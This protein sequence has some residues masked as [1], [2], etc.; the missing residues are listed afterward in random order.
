MSFSRA[1]V[2]R[3]NDKPSCA[4]PG[5][6]RPQSSGKGRAGGEKRD[7]QVRPAEPDRCTPSALPVLRTPVLRRKACAREE[8]QVRTAGPKDSGDEGQVSLLTLRVLALQRDLDALR[9]SRQSLEQDHEARLAELR[10]RHGDTE[11]R[12][13][14]QLA[15]AET[16]L[17]RSREE[18]EDLKLG[19]SLLTEQCEQHVIENDQLKSRIH[20]LEK[21]RESSLVGSG[22]LEKLKQ[23]NCALAVEL[24]GLHKCAGEIHELQRGRKLLELQKSELEK[25][26]CGKQ[27]MILSLQ[28]ELSSAA[29][30]LEEARL[31]NE[32]LEVQ[33]RQH[34]ALLDEFQARLCREHE[35][36]LAFSKVTEEKLLTLQLEL[37]TLVASQK[38][39]V[40]CLKREYDEAISNFLEETNSIIKSKEGTVENLNQTVQSNR[41]MLDDLQCLLHNL[42]RAYECE[43]NYMKESHK[44]ELLKVFFESSSILQS[45]ESTIKFLKEIL[46]ILEERLEGQDCRLS[47]L[48]SIQET[49]I[50]GNCDFKENEHKVSL[51]QNKMAIETGLADT[52]VS[53]ADVMR[54]H[55]EVVECLCKVDMED[56]NKMLQENAGVIEWKECVIRAVRT[57]GSQT[58]RMRAALGAK[59]AE[60]GALRSS[61]RHAEDGLSRRERECE[62][63]RIASVESKLTVM[64]LQDELGR[65]EVC[66]RNTHASLEAVSARLLAAERDRGALAGE[67]QRLLLEVRRLAEQLEREQ[68]GMDELEQSVKADVECVKSDLL[69]RLEEL[70]S[71]AA[72]REHALRVEVLEKQQ[73]VETL[74]VRLEDLRRKLELVDEDSPGRE[75]ETAAEELRRQ[76]CTDCAAR[77][78]QEPCL[79]C[80]EW[81][82][83]ARPGRDRPADCFDQL[84]PR[85]IEQDK[86]PAVRR[87]KENQPGA[88]RGKENQPGAPRHSLRPANRLL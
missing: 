78:E 83:R 11:A 77:P 16:R 23:V 5:V 54:K 20:I 59:E 56:V 80:R 40:N 28:S 34:T 73:M 86:E 13:Q 36:H 68:R 85:P 4:P 53:L 6:Y 58:E 26:V 2:Q 70:R 29:L 71:V 8:P 62:D 64:E 88:P 30:E 44:E 69:A 63:L 37:Q 61:L 50:V 55:E 3:F 43:V 45:K 14:E 47:D 87:G 41:K 32:E 74:S 12:L 82:R 19:L 72:E 7:R 52:D 38:D 81:E 51:Q 65:L 22:E 79:R 39:A 10:Q 67:N 21:E 25:K 17:E 42:E 66:R 60:L 31:E 49:E 57:A 27:E 9:D 33:S 46:V 75:G 1:K 35:A 15:L 76:L 24:Q 84:R 18:C 48:N